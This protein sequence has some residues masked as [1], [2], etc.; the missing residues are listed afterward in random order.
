MG[1]KLST[2]VPTLDRRLNGGLNPGDLMAIVT[3]PATQSHALIAQMMRERSTLYLTTLRSA[4]AIESDFDVLADS[5]STVIVE[6][7]ASGVSMENEFLHE[8]TG[9]RTYSVA[10]L[11][12]DGM[13]DDVYE[14]VQ[15]IDGSGNVVVDPTNPLERTADRKAYQEVLDALKTRLMETGSVGVLHCITH[16]DPPV[17]RE[18]TLMVADVVWELDVRAVANGDVEFQLRIPKNRRGNAVLEEITLLIDQ[19]RVYVDDSRNI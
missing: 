16:D 19:Q 3:A 12:D 10:S 4:S 18:T 1:E 13:L 9:S 2:G 6:D 17:F 11:T 8:L 14:A 7:V 5:E 15:R